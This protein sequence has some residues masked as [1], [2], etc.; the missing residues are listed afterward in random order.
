MSVPK[1]KR[2]VSSLDVYQNAVKL[3]TSIADWTMRNFGLKPD[4]KEIKFTA[5]IHQ[6]SK[7]DKETLFEIF[8]RNGLITKIEL[9]YPEWMVDLKRKIIMKLASDIMEGVIA[10]DKIF[11]VSAKDFI[12]RD[13][14]IRD[15]KKLAYKLLVEIQAVV[16]LFK[17]DVNFTDG[18][19]DAIDKEIA[20]LAGWQKN[21]KQRYAK[22]LEDPKKFKGDLE[23]K[24]RRAALERDTAEKARIATTN[25]V[26]N[27][28][29][30]VSNTSEDHRIL[31]SD[32]PLFVGG[33]DEQS[34]IP[35][36]TTP[37]KNTLDDFFTNPEF[38]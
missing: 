37:S 3:H 15:V 36:I 4:A 19:I 26:F 27:A 1:G 22:F 10:A 34:P 21:N 16:N 17:L 33:E 11:P 9:V 7:Q 35:S 31:Q 30:G 24:A 29:E 6:L 14:C 23:E 32:D 28:G 38:S 20:L 12:D 2:S 25:K 5:Q 18:L 8:E 13:S